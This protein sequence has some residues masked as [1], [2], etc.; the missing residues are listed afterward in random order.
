MISLAVEENATK[1][2]YGDISYSYDTENDLIVISRTAD[3]EGK[4]IPYINYYIKDNFSEWYGANNVTCS[5]VKDTLNYSSQKSLN[6]GPS[7]TSGTDC[8]LKLNCLKTNPAL[9]FGTTNSV[10]IEAS[11]RDVDNVDCG[12]EDME[13]IEVEWSWYKTWPLQK[14]WSTTNP[15]VQIV[16]YK[17]ADNKSYK[18]IVEIK[19]TSSSSVTMDDL[20]IL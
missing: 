17:D 19:P 10:L 3:S 4:I 9:T 6:F 20:Y 1:D 18:T 5:I 11:L 2:D 7:G 12:I 8:T 13:N 15:P 14:N 16:Q